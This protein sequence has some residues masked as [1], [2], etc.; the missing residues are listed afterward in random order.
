MRGRWAGWALW[1][2]LA[3]LAFL[4][5]A[6]APQSAPEV[7]T[8]SPTTSSPAALTQDD[9]SAV[10]D[11]R[12]LLPGSYRAATEADGTATAL[13]DNYFV[14]GPGWSLPAVFVADDPLQFV[15][16]QLYVADGSHPRLADRLFQDKDSLERF[17]YANLQER[18]TD[19]GVVPDVPDVMVSY[20][21][22]GGAAIYGEGM[23]SNTFIDIG[24]D[25]RFFR[26]GDVYL[27]TCSFYTAPRGVDLPELGAAL[28]QRIAAR[29]G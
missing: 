23:R 4:P 14:S 10:L 7:T 18:Q 3:A 1:C 22:V 16:C 28:L 17:L 24:F 27:L 26:T 12:G 19:C 9:V 21:A 2:S 15:T 13:Q 20:P 25:V 11:I 6:C 5:A 29:T 8:L